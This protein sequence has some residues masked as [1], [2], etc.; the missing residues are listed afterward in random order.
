MKANEAPEKIYIDVSLDSAWGMT[1]RSYDN[2]VEYT[3]TDAFIEKATEFLQEHLIDYLWSQGVTDE[4]DF[5][6]D[7]KNYMKGEQGM[8]AN[9]PI[10]FF[11]VYSEEEVAEIDKRIEMKQKEYDAKL[12]DKMMKAKDFPMTD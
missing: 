3:R 9:T 11:S 12:R 7:F 5:I 4:S 8:K 6:D 1:E 10:D 2:E